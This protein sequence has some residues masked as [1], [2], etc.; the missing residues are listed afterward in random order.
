MAEKPKDSTAAADVKADTTPKKRSRS[1]TKRTTKKVSAPISKGAA[2]TFPRHTLEDA[3]RVAQAIE[4][5]F[6]GKPVP[7][8]DVCKA[9]GYPQPDWRY[10]DLMRSTAQYEIVTWKGATSLV[11]IT[12]LGTDIVAPSDPKQRQEAMWRAFHSVDQFKRVSEHYEGKRIPED[13]FFANT[14]IREFSVP[15]DRVDTFIK[16]FTDNLNYLK[17]FTTT[18][19]NITVPRVTG[20]QITPASPQGEIVSS[21]A[22]QQ[23]I[24]AFLDTCFVL[25]PFGDWYDLY[26]KEVYIPA[27]REAGY[28]PVRADGLF[29]SGSVMEQIWE[30]IRKAKVLLADLTGKNP[31]VFYELGLAHARSKPVVLIA[32]NLDDVP[33]DLRHLR[34]VLYD[35]REPDWGKKLQDGI[36]AQLKAAK[37]DPEKSIPQPYRTSHQSGEDE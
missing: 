17:S 35:Q 31:N 26:Y 5:K 8:E 34:V 4:E 29:T 27:T 14:L 19:D 23:G 22:P 25:M 6:A 9:V 30:Q 10:Q 20:I 12:N 37:A 7:A 2:W 16:V 11:D 1:K 24:R 3:I 33:F 18:L 28:E 13:E 15:R 36:A 21:E 32:G